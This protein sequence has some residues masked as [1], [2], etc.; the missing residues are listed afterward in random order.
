MPPICWP[1]RVRRSLYIRHDN[2]VR[3]D[4]QRIKC[5]IENN[6]V[7]CTAQFI[8]ELQFKYRIPFVRDK[9]YAYDPQ[10]LE[11]ELLDC[12]RFVPFWNLELL[13]GRL[14]CPGAY[15]SNGNRDGVIYQADRSVNTGAN[16]VA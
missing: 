15:N 12:N 4:S 5:R 9:V 1:S 14:Y 8:S 2:S 6:I 7:N 13:S 16:D 10:H 3:L 11:T